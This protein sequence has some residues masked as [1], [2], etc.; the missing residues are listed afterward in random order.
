MPF[1]LLELRKKILRVDYT[2]NWLIILYISGWAV[3]NIWLCHWGVWE[4]INQ[5]RRRSDFQ[6][7]GATNAKAPK[8]QNGEIGRASCRERV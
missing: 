5:H 6:G 2:K 8:G 3:E 4:E 7:G 1:S